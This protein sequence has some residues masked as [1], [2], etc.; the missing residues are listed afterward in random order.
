MLLRAIMH[1]VAPGALVCVVGASISFAAP[2]TNHELQLDVTQFSTQTNPVIRSTGRWVVA[3]WTNIESTSPFVDRIHHAV[4]SDSGAT[5]FEAG[6][7]PA[8]LDWYWRADPQ[9][10]VSA[11]GNAIYAI[12][13]VGTTS[14]STARGLAAVKGAPVGGAWIWGTP[15]VFHTAPGNT[16]HGRLS[17]D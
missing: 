7:L 14:P 5:F 16:Q 2:P 11:D 10:A 15:Q 3:A 12:G 8:M 6:P 17:F 9:L 1:S 4:S 13:Q